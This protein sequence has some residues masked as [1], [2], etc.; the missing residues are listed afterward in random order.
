MYSENY[1][2]LMKEIKDDTE[3]HTWFLGWENQYCEND[4]STQSSLQ[5]HCKPYQ[6]TKDIF[7]RIRAASFNFVQNHKKNPEQQKQC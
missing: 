5:I 2:I 3:R 7:Y 4:Y 6:I 1:K